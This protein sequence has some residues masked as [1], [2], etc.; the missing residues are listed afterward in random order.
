MT[1]TEEMLL[2]KYGPTMSMDDLAEVFKI[3]KPS[4]S[5]KIGAGKCP[6]P[7]HKQSEGKRAPRVAYIQDVAKYLDECR[8]A[9]VEQFN[10]DRERMNA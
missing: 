3:E 5:N 2:I 7:T 8:T 10:K 4:L 6:V 9:A 1:E